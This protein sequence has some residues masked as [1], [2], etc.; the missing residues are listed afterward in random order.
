M[1]VHLFVDLHSSW[2]SVRHLGKYKFLNPR[3][4]YLLPNS[5]YCDVWVGIYMI[6]TAVCLMRRQQLVTLRWTGS[7][8]LFLTSQMTKVSKKPKN[9]GDIA[10]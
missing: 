8:F 9:I 5:E 10:S 3:E 2:I 6:M 4:A 7:P 1:K